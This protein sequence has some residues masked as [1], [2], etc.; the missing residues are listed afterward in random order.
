MNYEENTKQT[1]NEIEQAKPACETTGD[2]NNQNI[3][4]TPQKT[5]TKSNHSHPKSISDN[6]K[7]KKKSYVNSSSVSSVSTS[8]STSQSWRNPAA[9]PQKDSEEIIREHR[10]EDRLHM[11]TSVLPR[12]QLKIDSYLDLGCGNC[13]ISA[14]IASHFSVNSLVA[15]DVYPVE[16]SQRP[17]GLPS[18]VKFEYIANENNKFTGV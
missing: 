5:N 14:K 17:Q 8:S 12:D 10:A 7:N 15:C 18:D 3:F 11:L 6:S 2:I 16:N 13:E 4:L 9:C 1:N